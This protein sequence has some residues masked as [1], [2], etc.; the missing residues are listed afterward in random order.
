MSSRKRSR[1]K[2]APRYCHHKARGQAYCTL[3]SERHYLGKFDSDE[4]REAYRRL[5]AEKW[6]PPGSK[7]LNPS[8]I[9]ATSP[10]SITIA[11][12]ALIYAK[13]P[14]QST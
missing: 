10:E 7:S 1:G 13:H 2:S 8:S 11:E 4:S 9:L 12:L 6:N 5:I 14:Q 3:N